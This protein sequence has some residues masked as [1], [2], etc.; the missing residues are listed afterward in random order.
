MSAV[1]EKLDRKLGG[2]A[3]CHHLP[4]LRFLLG[5]ATDADGDWSA[6][7]PVQRRRAIV[8]AVRD[9]ITPSGG[10][11]MH[12]LVCEDL[13]WIDPESQVVL[14][15]IEE[16]LARARILL[17]AT[18][19]PSYAPPVHHSY[20]S[21]IQLPP[22]DETA[23]DRLL[24]NLI[25]DEVEMAPLRELLIERTGGTPLF[26]EET[27]RMLLETGVV[28]LDRPRRLLRSIADI[29]I[30]ESVQAVIAARIDAL[31]P[32]SRSLLQLASVIG[33][34][35]PRPVLALVAELSENRVDVDLDIVLAHEFLFPAR[36][37]AET[38][39]VF[40]HALTQTVT[41]EGLLHRHR[42][43]LHGRVLRAIETRYADRL[44][45]FTE[46]LAEHALKAG[47]LD[48]AVRYLGRAGQRANA[49]AAHH[50]AIGFFEQALTVYDKLPE[51]GPHAETAIEIH[52]GLRVA[53]ASTAE[54]PRILTHL[55]RAEALARTLADH[56]RL[57]LI[58]VSQA[59][60]RA[61]LGHMDGAVEAGLAGVRLAEETGDLPLLMSARFALGQVYSFT[62]DL[63]AVIELLHPD[64]ERVIASRESDSAGTTGTT[65]VL[66]LCCLANAL[67]LS[68]RFARA[69]SICDAATAIAGITGRPYDHSYSQLS[70]GVLMFA[71]GDPRH[72][73]E[74][75]E[76][77]M[78]IAVERR[79]RVL[80][81]SIARFVGLAH[82][83]S[84]Q[85]V[86]AERVL[87]EAIGHSRAQ[88]LVV[89][90][91][92]CS[93]ALAWVHHAA[94]DHEAAITV[95]A[96]ALEIA[97]GCDLGPIAVLAGRGMG[98]AF[99]GRGP[100]GHADAEAAFRRAM[101]R[102]EQAGMMPDVAHCHAEL[103]RLHHAADRFGEAMTSR[104]TA[105]SL[106]TDLAMTW[107]AA[108]L[109]EIAPA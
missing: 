55:D 100:A 27:A 73:L 105:R 31:P 37:S 51:P 74:V 15:A 12:L 16:S 10:Q 64:A 4:A 79:I 101:A 7:E 81:P 70:E 87:R 95:A 63:P 34:D 44:G 59:N 92:W 57:L 21:L 36:L 91:A 90:D 22:L 75:L 106:Y 93:A 98:R 61:L 54:L 53:L 17:I 77:A 1:R 76:N 41:Y 86:D 96:A 38:S 14:D 26:L 68:G 30:P 65:S 71:Q 23:S 50:M 3:H 48:R 78:R 88:G 35:I 99:A 102:A 58:N 2:G 33:M 109:E 42:R 28:S 67:S 6:L 9:V 60:I 18:F 43:T 5:L 82:A 107:H 19:R 24:R 32:Q 20:F 83:A 47:D 29:Q 11:E 56:R 97:A 104:A 108:G 66:Y 85:L 103:A 13:H 52:L 8:A 40:K 72:A 84:G 49:H 94:G 45:E 62:G 69:R 39:Y 25:G 80:V 89:F 46:R